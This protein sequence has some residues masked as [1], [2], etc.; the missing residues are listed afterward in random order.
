[1]GEVEDPLSCCAGLSRLTSV[2]VRGGLERWWSSDCSTS[3]SFVSHTMPRVCWKVLVSWNGLRVLRQ[4]RRIGLV[5]QKGP[6]LT[7]HWR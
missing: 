1:M 4:C 5:G 2:A 7:S 3:G 6:T